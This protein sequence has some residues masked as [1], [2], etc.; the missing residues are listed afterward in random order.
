VTRRFGTLALDVV[1]ALKN[2]QR[3]ARAHNL[4]AIRTRANN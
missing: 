2:N 1:R 3:L 4:P